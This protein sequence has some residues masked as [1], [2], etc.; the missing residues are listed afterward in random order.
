[1]HDFGRIL[2]SKIRGALQDF[3][4]V[5]F[6]RPHLPFISPKKYWDLYDP[7]KI[8]LATNP[9]PPKGAPKYSLVPGPS[10]LR[11]YAGTPDVQQ[12]P[13][14]YARELKHGYY[15]AVT[16]VD[17]QIGRVLQELDSLGLRDNTIIVL[18]GDHG[19]KLGEHQAWAKH[20]NVENDTRVPLIIS[21]PG[22]KRRGTRTD[23]LV[24]LVDVY[25]TLVDLAGLPLPP[26]LEGRSFKP[27]L[28]NPGQ[29]WKGAA[30]S[31]YPRRSGKLNLMGYSMRT[32]RYRLTR[33]VDVK[34]HAKVDSVELYDEEQDPEENTNI[35]KDPARKELLEKLTQQWIGGWQRENPK[36]A[37]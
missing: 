1:M 15:A 26:H 16:Y 13:E 5:G 6:I 32:G 2:H 27:L 21:A 23:A 33:W 3:L 22:M 11:S 36:G 24:E 28:D 17:V 29:T 9:F 4:G 19:W 10:E 31:Q 35:A 8:P 12:L 30:F 18:W 34:D 20:S 25:P 14:P 7:A 37:K